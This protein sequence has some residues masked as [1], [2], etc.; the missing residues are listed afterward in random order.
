MNNFNYLQ[1]LLNKTKDGK[2]YKW[3]EE[4]KHNSK[5]KHK[6]KHLVC[7]NEYETKPNLFQQGHRCPKCAIK[8]NSLKLIKKNYLKNLLNEAKDGINYKWLEEYKGKNNI[9]IK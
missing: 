4:Y 6:I 8:K 2:D 5:L 3:L 9:N 7:G 1:N